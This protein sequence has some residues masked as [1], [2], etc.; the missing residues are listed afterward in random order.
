MGVS[1]NSDTP[2]SSNLIGFSIINHP[3]WGTT[4]LGN[5]QMVRISDG[6][7][8]SRQHRL[9]NQTSFDGVKLVLDAARDAGVQDRPNDVRQILWVFGAMLTLL[10]T[11][12]SHLRKRK[13]IFKMPFWGDMLVP[14]R[15]FFGFFGEKAHTYL[16]D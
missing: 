15:V 7:A 3:F 13:I 6:R 2:K 10:G 9:K 4:I 16:E 14:W 1:E 12:I 11:N 5:T 8:S